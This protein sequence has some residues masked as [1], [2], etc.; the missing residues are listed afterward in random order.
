MRPQTVK[1]DIAM[2]REICYAMYQEG[3]NNSDKCRKAGMGIESQPI[4]KGA[5]Q[6][7]LLPFIWHFDTFSAQLHRVTE[8]YCRPCYRRSQA[9]LPAKTAPSFNNFFTL[10]V[11]NEQKRKKRGRGQPPRM[12]VN[13]APAVSISFSACSHISG[14]R[15]PRRGK[16]VCNCGNTS[17]RGRCTAA[18]RYR[19]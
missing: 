18:A 12:T 15:Q 1:T 2:R 16:T 13:R 6:T 11:R 8:R 10:P 3:V 7:A 4:S 14:N 9:A 17:G 19:L 5:A